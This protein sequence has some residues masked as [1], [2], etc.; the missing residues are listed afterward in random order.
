M[1]CYNDGVKGGDIMALQYKRDILALLKEHGFSTYILRRD[2]LLPE[3]TIQSIR[4]GKPISWEN[5]NRICALI[6]CQPGDIIE[7][8]KE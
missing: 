2:K 6:D 5:I 1:I 8:V 7:Y 4:A 3:S